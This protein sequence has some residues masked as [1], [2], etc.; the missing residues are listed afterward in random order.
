MRLQCF[1][2]SKTTR[3]QNPN[4]KKKWLLYPAHRIH[5]GLQNRPKIFCRPKP[6]LHGLSLSK[7]PI[8][9]VKSGHQPDQ[10]MPGDDFSF[11]KIHPLSSL[12][13]NSLQFPSLYKL[14][15]YLPK[16]QSSILLRSLVFN[17]FIAEKACS[18]VAVE[19][20]RV[21]TRRISLSIK[22]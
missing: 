9:R 13:W 5:N 18:V 20:G 7:S 4:H 10:I 14:S 17:N 16:T 12:Y 21:N 22:K 15:Y 1:S 6:P 19:T 2:F 3:R 11:N 8:I